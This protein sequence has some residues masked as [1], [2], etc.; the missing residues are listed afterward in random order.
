[1]AA[2]SPLSARNR[3]SP[4]DAMNSP[5]AATHPLTHPEPPD[6][7]ALSALVDALLRRHDHAVNAILFY[8]SCLRSGDLFDGLVD[9][10]LIVDDYT[11]FYT[12]KTRALANWLLP[13]TVFYAEIGVA[14][15]IVRAKY[16]VLSS[17]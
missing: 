13:P 17:A 6:S 12:R 10:Y 15:R 1:M 14:D 3:L 2:R 4:T 7:P 16:A 5:D 9:L 8:G 11:A